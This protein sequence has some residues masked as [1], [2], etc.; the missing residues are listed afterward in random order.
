MEHPKKKAA[1]RR[2]TWADLPDRCSPAGDTWSLKVLQ[3]M[4][5]NVICV[6]LVEWGN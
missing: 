3:E 6:L 4:G 1:R 5:I 2:D